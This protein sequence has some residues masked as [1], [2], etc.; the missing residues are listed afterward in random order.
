ML[1]W[2]LLLLLNQCSELVKDQRLQ[3]VTSASDLKKL[4]AP[5]ANFQPIQEDFLPQKRQKITFST[6]FNKPVSI[7]ISED[8]DIRN[9][10]KT[11]GD[12]IG[13]KINFLIPETKG[14]NYSASQKPFIHL[15]DDICDAMNLRFSITGINVKIEQDKPFFKN[16]TVHFLKF[17]RDAENKVSS[18][19]DA[20]KEKDPDGEFITQDNGSNSSVQVKSSIDFWQELETSLKNNVGGHSIFNSQ[21]RRHHQR[22]GNKSPAQDG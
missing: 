21:T 13:I 9:I 6:E 4:S 3:P 10:L 19:T 17:A 14:L 11:L 8:T 12:S 16:Y 5:P 1:H 2:F 22:D 15:L 20:L 18:M 7:E